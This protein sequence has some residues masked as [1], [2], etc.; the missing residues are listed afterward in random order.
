VEN[1]GLGAL[2]GKG[3][4]W[5]STK[6]IGAHPDNGEVVGA[7]RVDR[8]VDTRDVADELVDDLDPARQGILGGRSLS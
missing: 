7:R 6:I 2:A 3:A 8:R 5:D 4:A 1:Q